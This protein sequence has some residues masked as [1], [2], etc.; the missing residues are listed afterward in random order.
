M[1][2]SMIRKLIPEKIVLGIR[3]CRRAREVRRN[4]MSDADRYLRCSSTLDVTE[5]AQLEAKITAHF[6]VLEK[7]LA[8]PSRRQGFGKGVLRSL[9]E[10][11]NEYKSRGYCMESSQVQ[12]SLCVLDEYLGVHADIKNDSDMAAAAAVLG[13]MPRVCGYEGGV[14]LCSRDELLAGA[15][16]D[17]R[18]LA[19]SRHSIRDFTAEPVEMGRIEEAVRLAQR[20]PSVCNR[21]TGRAYVLQ[22]K[23][24]V[25]NVLNMSRGSRGF[26]HL[27]DKLIMVAA[28]L[29]VFGGPGER[30][31]AFVD[32]GLFAMSLLYA[33]H[34]VEIGACPLNWCVTET[35]DRQMRASIGIEENDVVL[36]LIAIGNLPQEVKLAYSQRRALSEVLRVL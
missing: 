17:F 29:R 13:Q 28:D 12:S 23:A 16:G 20:S 1:I 31:Q 14:R 30:N 21:Q 9:I 10:L 2:R 7:G 27:V 15:K 34:Y 35:V 18:E 6:H 25:E 5:Q 8:M 33:L 19:F 4:C 32:G 24:D 36:M 3:K 26:G 11:L 22:R